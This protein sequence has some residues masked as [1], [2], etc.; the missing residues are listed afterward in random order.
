MTDTKALAVKLAKKHGTNDPFRIVDELGFI[1]I[2][3]PLVDMRGFQQKAKR[4]KFIYIN[5][6]LDE[7]Q[8]RLVCAHEL[9]HHLMHRNMNRIF[10]DHSTQFVTQ[11]YENEAHMFSLELLYSDEELAEYA[12]HP[13]SCAAAYMGVPVELAEWRMSTIADKILE[14]VPQ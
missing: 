10:M 12:T 5:S 13:I 4:R 7:Q 1:V 2:R 6:N 11:K 8:Q 9:G 14:K 3:A